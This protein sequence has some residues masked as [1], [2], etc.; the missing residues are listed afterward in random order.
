MMA[1]QYE[2]AAMI[3]AAVE[4]VAGSLGA[5]IDRVEVEADRVC[6]QA[7]AKR[8]VVGM[9]CQTGR[10]ADGMPALGGSWRASGAGPLGSAKGGGAALAPWEL[11]LGLLLDVIDIA[12]MHLSSPIDEIR[13]RKDEAH[14]E[15][16]VGETWTAFTCAFKG[17]RDG[18][19]RAL[20]GG[21]SWNV[22]IVMAAPVASRTRPVDAA[23]E[24]ME[25]SDM[26]STDRKGYGMASPPVRDEDYFGRSLAG[27]VARQ[28]AAKALRS[29][30]L[31]LVVWLGVLLI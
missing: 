11:R 13:V 25:P 8:K 31:E 12:A 23:P 20:R 5:P 21:A 22:D 16:R 18:V 14:A 28:E 9:S 2:R 19:G 15:A 17:P 24:G 7:G 10:D 26:W 30:A 3:K 1:P 29:G 4:K 27:D 6:V